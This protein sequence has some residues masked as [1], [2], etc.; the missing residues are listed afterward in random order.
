MT[1]PAGLR[2]LPAPP[3]T[4]IQQGELALTL[5]QGKGSYLTLSRATR[6][7]LH[8]THPDHIQVVMS[9]HYLA[10]RGC[11]APD[12]HARAMNRDGSVWAPDLVALFGIT[13]WQRL[14]LIGVIEQGHMIVELPEELRARVRAKIGGAR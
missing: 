14:R 5:S 12:Q 2:L 3:R 9:D 7:A 10:V 8:L 4:R 6:R 13:E 1:L 11:D